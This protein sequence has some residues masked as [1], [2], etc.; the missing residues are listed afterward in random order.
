MNYQK[1][2]DQLIEIAKQKDYQNSE[3][4][5][6]HH[7]IPKC[8]GG[9]NTK[10]NKVNLTYREHFVAHWLL[11]NIYPESEGL[12]IAFKLMITRFIKKETNKYTPS[13]KLIQ[14][15]YIEFVEYKK[16]DEYKEFMKKAR[17]KSKQPKRS[18]GERKYLA[19]L[20]MDRLKALSVI[21]INSKQYYLNLCHKRI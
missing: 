15:K 7:I 8:M 21:T 16:T 6:S 19:K 3:Y 10:D 20:E 13:S 17:L 18:L 14:E 12:K 1:I 9:L 5:Q 2:Y 11:H 4:L